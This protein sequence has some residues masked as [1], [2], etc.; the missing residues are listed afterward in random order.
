MK[1]AIIKKKRVL[2]VENIEKPK[3]AGNEV[4]VKVKASG[5][6]GT[7]VHVYEDEVPIAKLPVI[8]GHEFCGEVEAIGKDIKDI[9]AGDRIAVEPNL[10]CGHCHFCRTAKKHFCENWAAVGLTRSGGFAEYCAVPRQAVY[11]IEDKL[12]FNEAAFFEPVAC[13]LH[14]IERSQVKPGDSVVVMGAGSIGLIYVQALKAFGIKN[15]ISC[16]IDDNKLQ[17]AKNLGADK[18][19][20]TKHDDVVKVVKDMTGGLGVESVI[21]AAGAKATLSMAFNLVQNCGSVVVFGVPTEPMEVNM[22]D[23]YRREISIIGSFT[24]P[25]TNEQA[26]KLLATGKIKF[27]QIISHP[28]AIDDVE[29]AMIKMRDRTETVIKAQ[30]RF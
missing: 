25:Y 10:F 15:V 24:N 29:S 1:A 30:I 3:I 6:C 19:L 28:V 2:S 27:D 16:D 21:D 14:G 5:V 8:P 12:G 26:L 17:I 13:V 23:V 22:Y 11:K 20:N 4:L 7:D 18:V 9:K